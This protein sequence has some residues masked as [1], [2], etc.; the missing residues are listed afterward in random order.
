MWF[1]SKSFFEYI[2]TSNISKNRKVDLIHDNLRKI[3][4]EIKKLTAKQIVQYLFS[5]KIPSELKR[6]ISEEINQLS[7]KKDSD[8]KNRISELR[9]EF[10]LFS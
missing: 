1:I 8:S 6:V 2:E 3:K 7:L 5:S 9:E 4:K 10:K